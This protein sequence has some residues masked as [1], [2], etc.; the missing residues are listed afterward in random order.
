MGSFRATHPAGRSALWTKGLSSASSRYRT[1]AVTSISTTPGSVTSRRFSTGCRARVPSRASPVPQRRARVQPERR[2]APA[3]LCAPVAGG[4]HGRVGRAPVL[5]REGSPGHLRGPRAG[6]GRDRDGPRLGQRDPH[7]SRG[8]RAAPRRLRSARDRS[9]EQLKATTEALVPCT[10][11]D[12]P[13]RANERR[14]RALEECVRSPALCG[15]MA[16]WRAPGTSGASGCRRYVQ[17]GRPERSGS[18]HQAWETRTR[19][20]A[21]GLLKTLGHVAWVPTPSVAAPPILRDALARPR[22]RRSAA[23]ARPPRRT[24]SGASAVA[25]RCRG[26]RRRGGARAAADDASSSARSRA[27]FCS[28]RRASTW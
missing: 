23:R 7:G 18:R 27:M 19:G 24:G 2:G 20:A 25:P 11:R 13:A 1:A 5:A 8:H 3:A 4:A 9:F 15:R 10:L 28:S 16:A 14:A 12:V 6:H 22:L 17:P 26:R 21:P